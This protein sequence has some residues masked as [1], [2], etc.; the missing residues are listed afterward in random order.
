MESAEEKC[1]QDNK[2]RRL[3]LLA[4]EKRFFEQFHEGCL[5]GPTRH[6]VN[7]IVSALEFG[8]KASEGCTVDASG[9]ISAVQEADKGPHDEDAEMERRRTRW[10]DMEFWDDM[11]DWTG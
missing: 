7:R 4:T 11:N 1:S 6:D 5:H 3:Q 2:R 10:N 8:P 9:I